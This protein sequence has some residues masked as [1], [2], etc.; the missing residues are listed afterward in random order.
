MGLNYGVNNSSGQ[1]SLK[2]SFKILNYAFENGITTLD[3]AEAYG[4]AHEVIGKFHQENPNKIFKVITKLP[5]DI[6][7][8]I[9][10]KVDVYLID[11]NIIA[12]RVTLIISKNLIC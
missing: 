11:L 10:K 12:M 7:K 3:S 8:Q 6:N 5:K 9:S 4:N 1:V 2:D